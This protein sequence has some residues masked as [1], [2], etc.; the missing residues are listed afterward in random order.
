MELRAPRTCLLSLLVVAFCTSILA[1]DTGESRTSDSSIEDTR[2]PSSQHSQPQRVR[3]PRRLSSRHNELGSTE[4]AKKSSHMLI[5]G[6]LRTEQTTE[7]ITTSD[8]STRDKDDTTGTLDDGLLL[9]SA[10]NGKERKSTTKSS[11]SSSSDDD[12]KKSLSQ[13]VKE[14]KYGLIQNEI[15]PEKPK[16]PGIISYSSNPE[17]PRDTAKN[18]GGLDEE[19]IWLAE[20]HVLVL[21]GGNFPDPDSPVEQTDDTWPPIDDY[22]APRRQVKIP[23]RPKVPPPF[24]IQLVENG[25]I[26]L[27]GTNGTTLAENGTINFEALPGGFK[28]FLPGEGPY[29]PLPTVNNSDVPGIPEKRTKAEGIPGP[30]YPALPPGAVIVPPPSNQTDYDDEDQSI[31]YPPP[32]SFVYSQ[33][34]STAIPPGPLVPG[35]ILPPPPDFFSS[36]DEKKST[37][38][39]KYAKRPST[40]PLPVGRPSYLPPR[41]SSTKLYKTPSVTTS[42]I[43][44]KTASHPKPFS[45]TKIKNTTYR[46]YQTEKTTKRIYST[47]PYVEV[48]TPIPV[49]STTLESPEKF[50]IQP[51]LGNQVVETSTEKPWKSVVNARP[52]PILTF[53]ATTTPTS[54]DQPVE[55]TPSAVKNILTTDNPT[56]YPSQASYYFY[57]EANNEER[58]TST[59]DPILFF[60]T[61]A[62]TPPYYKVEL[63][64]QEEPVE[65]EEEKK[66]Y[67]DVEMI[68]SQQT[69]KDY[70]VKLIDSIVKDPQIY[71]YLDSGATNNQEKFE[72]S[73]IRSQSSRMLQ[74]EPLYYQQIPTRSASKLSYFTTPRPKTYYHKPEISETYEYQTTPRA[75]PIYQY[76]FEATNYAKRGSQSFTPKP[77]IQEQPQQQVQIQTPRQ[78]KE[79]PLYSEY[80]DIQTVSDQYDYETRDAV[81][82]QQVQTEKVPYVS[83]KKKERTFFHQST[84]ISPVRDTTLASHQQYFTKQDEKLLDDVTKEYFTMFGKKLSGK[85]PSTTPIYGKSSVTERPVQRERFNNINT[86][87]P[88]EYNARQPNIFRTSNVKVHYGDQTPGPFSLQDDILVNYKN[89]LPPINPDAEFISVVNPTARPA[90]AFTQKYRPR[91][92]LQA[93]SQVRDYSLQPGVSGTHPRFEQIRDYGTHRIEQPRPQ[94]PPRNPTSFVPIDDPR[95]AIRGAGGF[96]PRPISL[97]GDIA[98]NY[99]NPRPPINPD[100]EFINSAG[101]PSRVNGNTEKANSYFAYRLP[102]DGGHFYF[103]TPQA[104]SRADPPGGYLYSRP[105]GSRLV[106]RRRGRDSD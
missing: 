90:A 19:E 37:I 80:Q 95:G 46:P 101:I 58:P 22:K 70:N 60:S 81:A 10:G 6:H 79:L 50:R 65:E 25:P 31:Y 33:D 77:E 85:L 41:K 2:H 74:S 36:L 104:I 96:P 82:N 44:S 57:E 55:T 54:V 8:T 27:I 64:Q 91:P 73:P 61:T 51:I 75:K 72:T 43:G 56:R 16:R 47:S 106:R 66:E 103:L 32:Y 86:Y 4:P 89:P 52:L 15:Y 69:S 92:V 17:V 26:Q 93:G 1:L 14:G 99:K 59:P 35:I 40:T 84:T 28:G 67:Y 49:K 34:N 98:V 100:A 45:R 5:A 83:P 21:K 53:Y 29:F 24:P 23:P 30:F 105:R 11:A 3:L 68:P 63:P 13:Q 78:Q 87:G 12:D 94:T 71:R 97:E 20:N 9:S 38:K 48:T 42:P 102:G 7:A 18:F 62:E 76:S 88:N 39:D